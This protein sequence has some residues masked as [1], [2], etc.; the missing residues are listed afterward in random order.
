MNYWEGK[1][2]ELRG[3]EP[4]DADFFYEWNK[5]T[6]TQK[7]LDQIWFPSSLFRQEKWVE[8]QSIKSI[9][10][11]SYFFVILN[12]V[13]EKVG[14]IHSHDCDKKNGNFGYGLGIIEGHRKKGYA[15]EAIRMLLNYYFQE[16]RYHKAIVGI[17]AF[18][19]VSIALHKKIGFKEEGRLREMLFGGNEFHDLLKFGL[20]KREFL[21]SG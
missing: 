21:A 16:L 4:G 20:L 19:Q 2:I 15:S 6:A 5:E 17:Y 18:N 13:G 14:M 3:I 12:K 8:K 7:N 10:D 1:Q 11:D 9:E